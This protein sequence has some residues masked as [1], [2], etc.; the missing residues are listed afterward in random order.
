MA[1]REEGAAG[2]E[3]KTTPGR[4][5]SRSNCLCDLVKVTAPSDSTISQW[6]WCYGAGA[7]RGGGNQGLSP[8]PCLSEL[9][10]GFRAV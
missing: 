9:K 2:T 5:S 10:Q 3:G 1:W 4:L 8:E 6:L 7:S